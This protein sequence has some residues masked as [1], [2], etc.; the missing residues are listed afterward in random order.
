MN[1]LAEALPAEID[2][3]QNE[4]MPAYRDIGIAGVPALSMMRASVQAAIRASA[5]GDV[6]AMI[7][8]YKDLKGYKL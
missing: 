7:A 3:V 5:A 4:V 2:R 6:I 8:A 1:N